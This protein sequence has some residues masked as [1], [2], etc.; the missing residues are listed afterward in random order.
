MV[1]ECLQKLVGIAEQAFGRHLKGKLEDE[2]RT[3]RHVTV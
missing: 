1:K 3:L 2:Y